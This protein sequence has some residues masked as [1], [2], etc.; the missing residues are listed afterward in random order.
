MKA[1]H[2]HSFGNL[3]MI[4][5]GFNSQQGNDDL[6]TKFG[7]L[8]SQIQKKTLESIKLLHMFN[9]FNEAG[10][11]DTDWLELATKHAEEMVKLLKE[12]YESQQPNTP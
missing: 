11:K 2:L 5:A 12:D 9:E 10:G 8:R 4:S 1:A 3:V 6:P 7:R